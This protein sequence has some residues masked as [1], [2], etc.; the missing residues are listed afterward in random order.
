MEIFSQ[1]SLIPIQ[2]LNGFLIF[3]IVAWV[4]GICWGLDMK[5][6]EKIWKEN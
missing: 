6:P 3:Y 1:N 2:I 5:Q 4:T